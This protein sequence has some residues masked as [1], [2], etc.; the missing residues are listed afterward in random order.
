MGEGVLFLE[1]GAG[2]AG[3]SFRFPRAAK[4]TA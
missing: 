4:A 1:R 3:L 2:R